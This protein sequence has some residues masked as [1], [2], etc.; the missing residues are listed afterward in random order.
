MCLVK[1]ALMINCL[2]PAFW[3]FDP[4]NENYSRS[5][6]GNTDNITFC[7]VIASVAFS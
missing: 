6:N 1:A 3:Q 2:F 4:A 5:R 7:A